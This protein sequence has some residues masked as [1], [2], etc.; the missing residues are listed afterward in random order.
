MD[1]TTLHIII[2]E[3]EFDNIKKA[4]KGDKTAQNILALAQ[5]FQILEHKYRKL[6]D[7]KEPSSVPQANE[8]LPHVRFQL[9]SDQQVV[10]LA[11]LFNDGNMDKEILTK[12]VSL[13]DFIIDR[14]YENGDI[15]KPS[16][17]EG[18]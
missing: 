5:A 12:M 9:P 10:E 15:S 3:L 2:G 16:S 7:G 14:L 18:N 13:A 1:F 4:A 17:K 11:I 8:L 6:C